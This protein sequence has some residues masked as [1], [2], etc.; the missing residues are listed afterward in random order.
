[1]VYRFFFF[2]M[3][4]DDDHASAPYLDG[5]DRGCAEIS[6]N[7]GIIFFIGPIKTNLLIW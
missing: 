7:K 5:A 4:D 1:M 3:D 6:H 2:S